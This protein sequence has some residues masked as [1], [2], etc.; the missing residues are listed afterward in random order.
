MTF[1]TATARPRIKEH[2]LKSLPGLPMLLLLVLT[3]LAGF[4]LAMLGIARLAEGAVPLAFLRP[5]P[6]GWQLAAGLI[7]AVV[8]TFSLA[9]LTIVAPNEARVVQLFGRYRGTVHTDGMRWVNPFTTRTK[10]SRRIRNH[11]T[12]VLKVN[13]ADGN[14][15]EISAVVVWQVEDTARATFEVDNYVDFVTIQTETAVRHTANNYPYDNLGGPGLSLRDNA[16]EITQK[17]SEEVAARVDAAGVRVIESRITH[18]AYASEIAQAMLQRQQASAVV[19]A[20]AQIVEGSI[21][22]VDMALERLERNGTVELD[23]ERKA[24]MVSNLLVV[25]CSD[26]ATKP[27]VNTG[28]IY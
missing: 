15:I 11:E 6:G 3:T 5:I 14:P 12:S 23:E 18:L 25:L 26:Q 21:G 10:I 16:E 13:D 8:S 7:I 28:S 22:M 1:H 17:L 9:G 27:V 4:G 2:T 20:R 19:S 24:T